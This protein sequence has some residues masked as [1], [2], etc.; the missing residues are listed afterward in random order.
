M[1][2]EQINH[3]C[4]LAL[5]RSG[6]EQ[7][8]REGGQETSTGSRL[9]TKTPSSKHNSARH[10]TP[11]SGE[12]SSIC[13]PLAA[14]AQLVWDALLCLLTS[15]GDPAGIQAT[16]K[17]SR[18]LSSSSSPFLLRYAA[19]SPSALTSVKPS[20][21]TNPAMELLQWKEPLHIATCLLTS[22]TSQMKPLMPAWRKLVTSKHPAA[23]PGEE[24][25]AMRSR[26]CAACFPHS[27][28]S[29][30]HPQHNPELAPVKKLS[31][32]YFYFEQQPQRPAQIQQ[33]GFKE[34][35]LNHSAL[36]KNFTDCDTLSYIST[37]PTGEITNSPCAGSSAYQESLALYFNCK[38]KFKATSAAHEQQLMQLNP[39]FRSGGAP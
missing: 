36:Q 22:S 4:F 6:T 5:A 2:N 38:A 23:F 12:P 10:H 8:V 29:E 30:A 25:Q 31:P 32:A 3:C 39:Q 28:T 35:K 15:L 34:K 18:A 17:T 26:R 19:P 13:Y 20:L 14:L 16:Q 9:C 27:K 1:K 33:H 24:I 11:W 21:E 37:A 7:G